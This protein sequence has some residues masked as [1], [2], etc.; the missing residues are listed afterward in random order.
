[1]DD[2]PSTCTTHKVIQGFHDVLVKH[3]HT[4]AKSSTDLGFC[5]ILEQDIDTGDAAP[6]CV[7]D[8]ANIKVITYIFKILCKH[9]VMTQT[10]YGKRHRQ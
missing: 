3:Q 1:V 2:A 6:I 4:F 8:R 5:I 10:R 7:E 9:T